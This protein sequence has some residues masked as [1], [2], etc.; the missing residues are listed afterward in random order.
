MYPVYAFGLLSMKEE[1]RLR[2]LRV[3]ISAYGDFMQAAW[4]AGYILDA[5]LQHKVDRLRGMPRH[6]TKLLWE[7]LNCAMVVSYARPFSPGRSSSKAT[8][9]PNRIVR[10]LSAAERELHDTI[11]AD[12]NGVMAHSDPDA[13]NH[14]PMLVEA[15]TSPQ[16]SSPS[17][18]M[19]V[20]QSSPRPSRHVQPFHGDGY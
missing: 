11:L 1:A 10:N 3:L 13:W 2:L 6:R 12:R 19:F 7:A 5:K 18:Q 4:I 8:H 17:M 20:L 15:R 9:L 14:R 16:S